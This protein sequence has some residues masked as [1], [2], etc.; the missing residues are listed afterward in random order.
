[1]AAVHC[2]SQATSA[3]TRKPKCSLNS[4]LLK[5]L[6]PMKLMVISHNLIFQS[7]LVFEG[8]HELLLM[9]D[10]KKLWKKTSLRC[11]I[12]TRKAS[13]VCV[14]K[15]QHKS[16]FCNDET[17]SQHKLLCSL[18]L[19]CKSAEQPSADVQWLWFLCVYHRH[20]D[21]LPFHPPHIFHPNLLRDFKNRTD[22]RQSSQLLP[23]NFMFPIASNFFPS[24]F[25]FRWTHAGKNGT[26]FGWN[27]GSVG[28][29]I[30][31]FTMETKKIFCFSE[32]AF[33]IPCRIEAFIFMYTS[34]SLSADK[35]EECLVI[36]DSTLQAWKQILR[37]IYWNEWPTSSLIEL[38][39]QTWNTAPI[40]QTSQTF[41]LIAEIILM[42]PSPTVLVVAWQALL[43]CKFRCPWATHIDACDNYFFAASFK[44]LRTEICWSILW[45][46]RDIS[47]SKSHAHS[48][49]TFAFRSSLLQNPRA[50]K[51][52]A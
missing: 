44:R 41:F 21:M 35:P 11:P 23:F 9:A 3:W 17:I 51:S 39:R 14:I 10:T 5:S 24:L 49:P 12:W 40:S 25:F 22:A 52:K 43:N 26:G 28:A 8:E 6:W 30:I 16:D 19:I 50:E 29:I 48:S 18:W 45:W 13:R 36:V 1:M 32:N 31:F 7:I 37:T 33:A 47:S 38:S 15:S 42:V 20:F 34:S 46:F 4:C 2:R 27:I